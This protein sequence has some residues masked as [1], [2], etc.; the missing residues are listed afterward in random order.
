[1]KLNNLIEE[2]SNRTKFSVSKT[3]II[4]GNDAGANRIVLTKE[5]EQPIILANS[6][7]D[8]HSYKHLIN[9]TVYGEVYKTKLPLVITEDGAMEQKIGY[10]EEYICQQ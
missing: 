1:M 9:K 7:H 4:T 3:T 8:Y 5:S 6:I 2:L 10:L